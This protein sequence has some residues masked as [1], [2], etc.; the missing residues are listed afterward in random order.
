MTVLRYRSFVDVEE[1]AVGECTVHRCSNG[2]ARWWLLCA[3]V[4][5]ETDGHTMLIAV[6]VAPN[7]HYTDSGPGGK[8]WALTRVAAARWQVAPSIN[9]LDLPDRPLHPGP[10]PTASSLWHQTPLVVG[11]DDAE[12]W[13][14]GQAP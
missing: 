13:T 8:T 11:V 14:T 1:L 4:A 3:S 12:T 5:A 7:G 9:V 10:H 2:Q 6:P